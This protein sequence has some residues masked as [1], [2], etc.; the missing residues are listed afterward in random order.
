MGWV[1]LSSLVCPS[2]RPA[3]VKFSPSPPSS[4]PPSSPRPSSYPTPSEMRV[5]PN[6]QIARMSRLSGRSKAS[7]SRYAQNLPKICP[8]SA[9]DMRKFCPRYGASNWQ[10][11]AKC[12]RGNYVAGDVRDAV[13]HFVAGTNCLLTGG[14]KKNYQKFFFRKWSEMTKNWSNHFLPPCSPPSLEGGPGGPN[15]QMLDFP[16]S[17][18]DGH[19][20]TLV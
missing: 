6:C 1:T 17:S 3:M 16:L 19:S 5:M 13:G 8:R 7:T 14:G 9:R 18:W 12:R 4:P 15:I 2:I 20:C 11:G 10:S